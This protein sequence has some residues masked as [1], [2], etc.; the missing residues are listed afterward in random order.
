MQDENSNDQNNDHNHEESHDHSKENDAAASKGSS[1]HGWLWVV[2]IIIVVA[3]ALFF[4]QRSVPEGADDAALLD[5]SAEVELREAGVYSIDTVDS[6]PLGGIFP[7]DWEVSVL[8]ASTIGHTAIHWDTES[9][10]GN[11]ADYTNVTQEYYEGEF[12][13]P[14]EF[15]TNIQAPEDAEAI[16]FVAHANIDG[17]DYS[18]EE[19]M[20][21][22]REDA[23]EDAEDED[24]S[25]DDEE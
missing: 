23:P 1:S 20:V 5:D 18:S 12:A 3:V 6:V 2:G 24:E 7:V 14:G 9:H 17:Q 4:L 16:Y 11:L 13:V 10:E 19:M 25:A 15:E 8:E 22:V 21:E